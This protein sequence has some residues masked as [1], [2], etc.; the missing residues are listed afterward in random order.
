MGTRPLVGT[1]AAAALVLA[2]CSGTATDP[3]AQPGAGQADNRSDEQEVG[4]DADVGL[5]EGEAGVAPPKPV[6]PGVENLTGE[7]R[8][9]VR[10]FELTASQFEQKIANF[11]VETAK[12]WGY[13]GS[14]PG[15]TIIANEGEEIRV[16]ITNELPP[17][18][19]RGPSMPPGPSPTA[20]TIHFHGTHMP[21][22]DDGV[23]GISQPNPIP[24]GESF[25]YQFT[26]EHAGSF[27]YHSHTDGAVQE[28][29]GL[30][31]ML[32]VLPSAVDPQERVD[33]DF[34]MTLQQFAPI[35][36]GKLTDGVLV[37]PFPPGGEFPIDTINGVTGDASREPLT[38][39]EGKTI[40]IRVYNASNSVH[41]MHLHGHDFT[42]TSINGHPIAPPDRNEVTT[43]DVGPGNFFEMEFTADNPGNWIFHC[44]FPHHTANG[45]FSGYN[46]APVG[47]TRVFHY[48]GYEP[49]PQEYFEYE[50][51]SGR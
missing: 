38:I 10:V 1:L 5:D 31:G 20:T 8:D 21:N 27:A 2:G 48:E 29:R 45:P 42:V 9:G 46:G 25:A 19:P 47:M 26:P 28:L 3:G 36:D 44:H 22:E 50:G 6:T 30:D 23:A 17:T 37:Q 24:P 39:R 35:Q 12:V 14:T 41:S 40:R 16:E 11:P 7:V 13:N 32:L 51:P 43:R 4:P 15:P 33:R 49:V 34:V 18:D